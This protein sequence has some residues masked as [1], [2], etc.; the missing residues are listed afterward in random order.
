VLLQNIQHLAPVL[1]LSHDFEI[2]FQGKQ[3]AEPVAKDG[4]VVRDHDPYL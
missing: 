2:F 4:M 3:A 1:G